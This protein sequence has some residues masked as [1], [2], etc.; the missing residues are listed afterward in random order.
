[1]NLFEHQD[2]VQSS[3]LVLSTEDNSFSIVFQ[4]K[5]HVRCGPCCYLR[6]YLICIKNKNK[7]IELCM[8]RWLCT[9]YSVTTANQLETNFKQIYFTLVKYLLTVKN[10]LKV[11]ES[12]FLNSK[13]IE[14]TQQGLKNSCEIAVL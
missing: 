10:L 5:G 6:Y 1:M 8:L 7:K 14:H 3:A 12:S 9:H 11:H 2:E 4:Q 13:K